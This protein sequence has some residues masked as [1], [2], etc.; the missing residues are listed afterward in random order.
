M[1]DRIQVRGQMSKW[2]H[3]WRV[4]VILG[5][6]GGGA[7]FFL[8]P[9]PGGLVFIPFVL[10][11]IWLETQA[12]I[13]RRNSTW[14]EVQDDGFLVTDRRG[15][16][17]Y[18]DQQVHSIAYSTKNVYNN[19]NFGGFTRSARLWTSDQ[20]EPLILENLIKVGT[21]DPLGVFLQRLQTLLRDGFNVGLDQG[22]ALEGEGWRLTQQDV[23]YTQGRQ[24]GS[25]AIKDIYAIEDHDG[26]MGIWRT[27]EELPVVQFPLNGRN[28]W[29]LRNV[30]VQRITK[31]EASEAPASGLGRI[32]FQRNAST[33][34]V[35]IFCIFSVML[36][37]GGVVMCLSNSTARIEDL[38]MGLFGTGVLIAFGT[39]A[40]SRGKFRCHEW[41]VFKAGLFGQN[42]L[43]YTDVKSFTYSA[44]RHYHNGAYTGTMMVLTFVPISPDK[45]KAI[46]FST[47]VRG[48]DEELERLRDFISTSIATR[49]RRELA[50]GSRVDWTANI[51]F[52][53]KG[54]EFRPSGFFGR[55][56]AVFLPYENYG[57]NTMKAGVFY[58]FERGKDKAVMQENAA[59]PNFFPG[60][61]MLH[62][63]FHQK[64]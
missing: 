15:E 53:P 12:A 23:S 58:I 24:S 39:F 31:P 30:L 4:V 20:T 60:W 42:Q 63:M 33:S 26:K 32:L 17:P 36:L 11:A 22:L 37:G 18:R 7:G 50:A 25:I 16:R 61:F 45:G 8:N 51:A 35:V 21:T 3:F 2:F 44:T 64:A 38:G 27:G 49:M 59:T 40:Y 14:I 6:V 54:F 41:G 5:A 46:S 34:S 9:V 55:K 56:E 10:L 29:I 13:N 47:T 48:G 43:K 28:I 1:A 19:G 62:Q 52:L 57:G